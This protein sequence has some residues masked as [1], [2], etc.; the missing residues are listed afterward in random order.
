MVLTAFTATPFA[1]AASR[2]VNHPLVRNS[3]NF[4]LSSFPDGACAVLKTAMTRNLQ[5]DP[6]ALRTINAAHPFGG[7]GEPENVARA[8]HAS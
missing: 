5:S 2:T 6:A 3:N 4:L 7:M 8:T 1:Q